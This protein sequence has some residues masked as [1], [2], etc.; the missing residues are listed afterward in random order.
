M[1]NRAA[2]AG[3]AVD[4]TVLVVTY[5]RAEP[6]RRALASLLRQETA[7]RFT[8]EILVIDDGSTDHTAGV[9][10]E[11]VRRAGSVPVRSVSQANAGMSAARN[12]GVRL[13]RGKWVALFDDDEEASPRWLLELWQTARET[14]ALCVD[15][16]VALQAPP[17]V[18]AGLGPRARRA[19]GETLTRPGLAPSQDS[20]TGGNV[21]IHRSLFQKVG[22]FAEL[23]RR[24]Q[25]TDF[26]WR[27]AQ[28]GVP[29]ASAPAALVH[30]VLPAARCQESYLRH[31][32]LMQGVADAGLHMKYAGLGSLAL[33]LLRRLAV[34]LA[35]DLPGLARSAVRGNQPRVLESRLGLW[36][37]WGLLRGSLFWTLPRLF[38]QTRFIREVGIF[39]PQPGLDH[40]QLRERFLTTTP[41][42]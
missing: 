24:D 19:L 40:L 23:L 11:A 42:V 16:R 21:L 26:F 39:F 7:G 5:N 30:H 25:D 2:G 4:V 31:L 34:V 9:V 12:R 13:A 18:L 1:T 28:A 22:G 20:M 6:L 17:A 8:Y 37:A 35:R 3:Q 10:A 36:Y 27:L 38:P 15:G 14:G 33:A 29:L 32:S 41:H